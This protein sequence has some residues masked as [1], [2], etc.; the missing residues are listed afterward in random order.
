MSFEHPNRSNETIRD[1][2]RDI[3]RR[4]PEHNMTNL[5]LDRMNLILDLFGHPEESF[6]VIHVTG[7]NGKGST[8]RM[9][10]AICRA[11]GMRTGLY[12]S[13]HLERINERIAID[14][15]QLS[16]DDFI[17]AW[18]QVKGIVDLVDARMDQLGKPRMSFFEVLTAMAIWKFAD[19]PVDVAVMEVGM[20]GRWDATN[21]IDADAAVIGPIDMDHMAWLGDT[22]E[23][24]AETKAGIIKPGCTVVVGRQPHE[25][26]V[27]PILEAEARTKGARIVRDGHEM[28]VVS[29]MPAVGGQVATLATPLGTY[30]EVPVAKFGE[31]QAHNAL[32]ALAAAEAVIP[33]SGAL[34]G[35]LVAE[36]LGGVKVPGRIE[37][38]RTSP[39]IIIDG[40]HN[41]NAAEALRDAIEENYHFEQLVAVVAMMGDK[42]VEEYLGVIEPVVSRIIVTENSWRERVMPAEELEKVAVRV[43]GP[44]RVTRIDDLPDA[45][46]EAVN[47]VDAEDE[48]GVGYG[49]GVLVCGS[50]VT[51]GDARTMLEERM[52]PDL[53]R[54]KAQRVNPT[55][56]AALPGADAAEAADA[57]EPDADEDFATDANPDFDAED[58][59]GLGLRRRLA[60]ASARSAGDGED[61]TGSDLDAFEE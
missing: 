60:K 5:D 53:A 40:G 21:A 59:T 28:E 15:Q 61:G 47:E 56:D 8:A 25:D 57:A 12:T 45:I 37:Q 46:Q 35:D 22:V 4:A 36:A 9:A 54:P 48:L 44:D 1:V 58:F 7:T 42:Q 52:N 20:G 34:D 14:G 51:A 26:E 11:Y 33:V 6:R 38:V 18:D 2:E 55:L 30:T 19:A 43:F 27:M 41:V 49:R 32:A 31:H 17:D 16:D 39:T 29:R 24:I 13:P 3:M 23:Q 10:E 50:F